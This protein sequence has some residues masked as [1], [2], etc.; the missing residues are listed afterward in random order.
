MQTSHQRSYELQHVVIGRGLDEFASEDNGLDSAPSTFEIVEATIGNTPAT[1]LR[2][3]P[4]T[5]YARS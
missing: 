5:N 1:A 2:R 3:S 4:A